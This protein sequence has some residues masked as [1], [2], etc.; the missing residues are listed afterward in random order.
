[1]GIWYEHPKAPWQA[2]RCLN[3]MPLSS[4]SGVDEYLVLREIE[5][6]DAMWQS[7]SQKRK[8][9]RSTGG[10]LG[11]DIK[12]QLE[13]GSKERPASKIAASEAT[14]VTKGPPGFY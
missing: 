10:D 7:G 12:E 8:S 13:P 9:K 1:M 11:T 2:L 3:T 6:E 4:M 14:S 5:H